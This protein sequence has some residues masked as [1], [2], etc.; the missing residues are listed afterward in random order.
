MS[1]NAVNMSTTS[2]PMY[3]PTAAARRVEKATASR[4]APPKTRP[5]LECREPDDVAAGL[6]N[7]EFDRAVERLVTRL[8]TRR[9]FDASFDGIEVSDGRHGYEEPRAV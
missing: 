2:L 8:D 5:S 3:S 1:T 4:S 6:A 7:V 9:V